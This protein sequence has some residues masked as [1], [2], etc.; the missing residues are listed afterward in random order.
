MSRVSPLGS[1]GG[2]RG[3]PLSPRALGTHIAL[4]KAGGDGGCVGGGVGDDAPGFEKLDEV[5]HVAC[6]DDATAV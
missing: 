3:T 1:G 2:V 5:G 4:K 6:R